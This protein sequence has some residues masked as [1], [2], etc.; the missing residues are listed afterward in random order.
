MLILKFLK[1]KPK[2]QQKWATEMAKQIRELAVQTYRCEFNPRS[3]H[4]G[5]KREQ[6]STKLSFN[7]YPYTPA[8][9]NK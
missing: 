4:K 1:T 3:P 7:L 8:M 2:Q 9:D 5:R 6:T